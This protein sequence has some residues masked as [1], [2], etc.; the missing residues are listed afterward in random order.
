MIASSSLAIVVRYLGVLL[1]P[2]KW[3]Y[4]ARSDEICG[5][6]KTTMRAS[7]RL[8]VSIANLM[9]ADG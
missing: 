8:C 4:E 2:S 3:L 5:R 6:H 9:N 7:R 1:D